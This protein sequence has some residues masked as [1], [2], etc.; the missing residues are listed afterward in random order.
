MAERLGADQPMDAAGSMMALA[1]DGIGRVHFSQGRMEDALAAWREALAIR[2]KHVDRNPAVAPYEAELAKSHFNI[3]NALRD[4]G[5]PEEALTEFRQAFG[6]SQRLASARPDVT[7]F[8]DLWAAS[9]GNMGLMLLRVGKAEEAIAAY[10]QG[11]AIFQKLGASHRAVG[12]IQN[13][14]AESYNLLGQALARQQRLAEALTAIDAG[15]G[16]RLKLIDADPKNTEYTTDLGV[17]YAYRGWTLVRLGQPS[18][19][20]ADLRLALDLWAKVNAVESETRFER[21]RALALLAKLG[22]DANSGVKAP[23]AIR[24]ADQ[25]VASLRDAITT[26]WNGWNGPDELKGPDFDALRG[27]ADFQ[28]LVAEVEAK[29]AKPRQAAQPA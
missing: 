10:R 28:K 7:E 3:G 21:S 19:A 11:L 12:H 16:I 4:L 22:G 17:S 29:A 6:I 27:R 2:Q 24:F 1:Y 5:K 13:G 26:G 14:L 25:A 8:Q 23:E 20:A 9:S 18:K 15:L